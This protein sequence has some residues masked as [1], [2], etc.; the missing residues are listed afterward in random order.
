[1]PPFASGDAAREK[2]VETDASNPC[3]TVSSGRS[4]AEGAF[5]GFLSS[6]ASETLAAGG[7]SGAGLSSST[8][9]SL[10]EGEA[11][12][13]AAALQL[14]VFVQME[15]FELSLE[16]VLLEGRPCHTSDVWSLFMQVRPSTDKALTRVVA[17]SPLSACILS[18]QS[19]ASL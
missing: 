10:A 6:F 8:A 9:S 1:M 16:K 15:Y 7:G 4:T 19:R 18:E 17:D 3:S 13:D 5:S 14:C 11:E 12:R 2:E